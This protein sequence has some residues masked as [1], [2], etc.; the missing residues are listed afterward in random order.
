MGHTIGAIGQFL[1]AGLVKAG[2]AEGALGSKISDFIDR[3]SG[4][5]ILGELGKGAA[6]GITGSMKMDSMSLGKVSDLGYEVLSL[7][8]PR[9]PQPQEE[10]II[11]MPYPFDAPRPKRRGDQGRAASILTQGVSSDTLGG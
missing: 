8:S 7:L 11:P 2:A 1:T 10:Q 6:L 5:G 9:L 3:S 4:G